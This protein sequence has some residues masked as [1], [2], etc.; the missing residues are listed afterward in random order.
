MN[1]AGAML[2][3]ELILFGTIEDQRLV[4]VLSLLKLAPEFAWKCRFACS[5]SDLFVAT[6][7]STACTG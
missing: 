6:I 7:A 3:L 1:F 5:F 4:A 2:R